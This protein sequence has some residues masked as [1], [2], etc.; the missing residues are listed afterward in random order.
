MSQPRRLRR[1]DDDIWAADHP[2]KMPGGLIIGT[3][4]T[5]IRLS[6]G[7]LFLHSPVPLDD[8]LRQELGELGPVRCIVAPNKLHY[9]SVTEHAEAFPEARV[10]GAP[11]LAQK[12]KEI[13]FDEELG[14]KVPELWAA[15]LDQLCVPGAPYLSEVVFLHKKSRTLLLTDLAFN[16][17]DDPRFLSRLFWKVNAVYQRFGPSRM[18]RA[19]MRDKKDVCAAIDRVLGWDFDRITVTHGEV[20]ETGGREALRRA[21]APLR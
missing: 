4:M 16:V 6:D 11:G 19:M 20:L 5:A 15:D 1:L 10:Y 13:H 7:G 21:Y 8:E 14:E 17:R 9:F 3:R 18:A 12:R 2:L